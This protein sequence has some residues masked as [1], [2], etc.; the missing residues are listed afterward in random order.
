[1]RFSVIVASAADFQAWAANQQQGPVEPAAGSAAEAGKAAVLD[2]KNACIGCHAISGTAAQGKIGP[3]LTHLMSRSYLA[4]GILA[5]TP[6]NLA[7]WLRD[8]QGVKPGN[9][10]AVNLDEATIQNIVAYL[11]ALQ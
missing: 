6:E 8:P 5:N 2:G 1:M 4:G 3:D 7:R 9:K 11:V 10:M